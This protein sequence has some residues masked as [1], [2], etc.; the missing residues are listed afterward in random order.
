MFI[1][2]SSPDWLTLGY[3][4]YIGLVAILLS[5]IAGVLSWLTVI[6]PLRRAYARKHAHS[7]GG[8]VGA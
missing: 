4:V 5:A 8:V 6:E 1:F 3:A 2:I 7:G